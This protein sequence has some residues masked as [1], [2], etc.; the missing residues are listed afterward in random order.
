M[1]R[2]V[3]TDQERVELLLS[4]AE[5]EALADWVQGLPGAALPGSVPDALRSAVYPLT[6]RSWLLAP[7]ETS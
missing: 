4:P 7:M 5:A 6:D 1:R 3:G 2:Y